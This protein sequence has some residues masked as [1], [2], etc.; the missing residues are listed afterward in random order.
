MAIIK[1]HNELTMRNKEN[2]GVSGKETINT[3]I[4]KFKY[5]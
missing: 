3:M 5:K 1:Y 4:I 2:Y